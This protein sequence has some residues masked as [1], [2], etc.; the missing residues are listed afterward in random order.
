M[1]VTKDL[2]HFPNHVLK[3]FCLEAQHPDEFLAN[4]LDLEPATFCSAARS[5]RVGKKNPPYT[6][7][8]YLLNLT[9]RG[10]VATVAGL[11]QYMLFLA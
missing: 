6:V 5:A 7:E 11:R 4:H 2:S 3:G 1:I 9:E 8:E 10:L